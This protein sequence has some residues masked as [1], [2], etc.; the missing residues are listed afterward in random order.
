VAWYCA[1]IV[2]RMRYRVGP[3]QPLFLMENIVLLQAPT[4]EEAR[5]QATTRG[6]L[7]S[8][9]DDPTFTCDDRP[10]Y[11]EFAGVRQLISCDDEDDRPASGTEVT[12]L[13]YRV[14]SEDDIARL[15]S[16]QGTRVE[17]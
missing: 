3:Q 5:I 2:M 7:D 9:E 12:Y 4:P 8:N 6:H 11:W 1:H 14:E 13:E 15:L 17:L 16:G 10:A